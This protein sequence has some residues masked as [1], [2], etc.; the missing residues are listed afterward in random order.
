MKLRSQIGPLR[1]K[2]QPWGHQKEEFMKYRL[3][4]ARARFWTMRTGKTK[5]TIDEC[6][7]LYHIGEITGVIVIAPNGVHDNWVLKEFPTHCAVDYEAMAFKPSKAKQKGVL[8]KFQHL[9]LNRENLKVLSIASSA[10]RTET[11]KSYLLTFLKHHQ[12]RVMVVFDEA[13]DFKKPGSKRTITA[14][15][16]ANRA[17]YKRL[18]TGTPIHG[19]VMNAYSEFEL[20]E[21]G[22]LGFTTY[23]DFKVYFG[24]WK[25]AKT[26]AGRSYV[27]FEG[28][29]NEDELTRRMEKFTTVLRREDVPGLMRPMDIERVFEMTDLQQKIYDKL[30]ENPVLDGDVLDGGVFLQK[31]QQIS[32]GFLITKE[33]G[34]VEI[35]KPEDNPRFQLILAEIIKA[36]GKVIVWLQ[37]QHE[38]DILRKLLDAEEIG[39]SEVH[40]RSGGNHIQTIYDFVASNSKKVIFGHALSGGV[41]GDLSVCNTII[42]GSHT[43]DLIQRD[44]ASERGTQIGK[45]PVDLIDIVGLNTTDRYILNAQQNKLNIADIIASTGLVELKRQLQDSYV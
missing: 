37:Y 14:R 28:P 2:T 25:A 22:A 30:Q 36:E 9:C 39:Y 32:S 18:L 11:A 7:F 3:S 29:K 12:N 42:W 10:L 23:E 1:F 40:G 20:L 16:V 27:K 35:V 21:K 5:V 45:L 6:A 17:V 44:Q 24:Q 31:L 4:K 19:N 13:H 41:G 34:L 38:M 8:A 26:R 15:G 43:F 33:R